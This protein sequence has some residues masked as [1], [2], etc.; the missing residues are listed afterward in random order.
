LCIMHER[1]GD[2]RKG[3]V[4]CEVGI[5]RMELQKECT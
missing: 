4:K 5:Y 1:E 3:E 2:A